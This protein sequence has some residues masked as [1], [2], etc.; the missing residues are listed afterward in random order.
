MG[1]ERERLDRQVVRALGDGAAD[2]ALEA[3]GKGA[4]AEIEQEG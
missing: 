1:G 4:I 2:A 3:V